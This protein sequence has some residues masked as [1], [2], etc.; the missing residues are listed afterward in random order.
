MSRRTSGEGS[1]Q[2]IDNL[3]AVDLGCG[4]KFGDGIN[5]WE[6]SSEFFINLQYGTS[7]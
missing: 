7:L 2:N 5:L 3:C 1:N 4:A 6:I